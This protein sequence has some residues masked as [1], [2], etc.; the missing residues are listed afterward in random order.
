MLQRMAMEVPKSKSGDGEFLKA[1][2][3]SPR[4]S[5]Q[6]ELFNLPPKSLPDLLQFFSPIQLHMQ[7]HFVNLAPSVEVST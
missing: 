6:N 4:H 5:A 7:P 2:P 3:R 1:D